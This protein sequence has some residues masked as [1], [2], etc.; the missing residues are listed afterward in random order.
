MS[1]VHADIALHGRN[2]VQLEKL[3]EGTYATVYKV[4]LF[5][6]PTSSPDRDID[7]VSLDIG[8]ITDDF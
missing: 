4:N 6:L 2:Y 1:W 7:M 8:K 3:G 5:L